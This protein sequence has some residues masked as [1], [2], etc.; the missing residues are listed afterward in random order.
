MDIGNLFTLIKSC[1]KYVIPYDFYISNYP[2]A[3]K[4]SQVKIGDT[5]DLDLYRT[6]WRSA[7]IFCNQLSRQNNFKTTY[8]EKSDGQL[9]SLISTNTLNTGIGFDSQHVKNGN[10]LLVVGVDRK[11]EIIFKYKKNISKF[12]F[13]TIQL[14]KNRKY[15]SSKDTQVLKI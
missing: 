14:P 11:K 13:S 10:T 7:A 12:H 8:I 3:I 9:D 6:N 1:D 15:F 5:T 4:A 2:V